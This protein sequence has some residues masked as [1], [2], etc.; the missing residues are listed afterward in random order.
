[1]ITFTTTILKFDEQGEKTGWTYI[2]I[3]E[4]IAVKIKPG[5]KKS[6]RVKGKLDNFSIKG[7]ALLPMG[8]GDFI[9]PL[10]ANMRKA[11]KKRQGAML[12]VAIT[13]DAEEMRPPLEL[14]ECL[15][16]EPAAQACFNK[17]PKSHQ[18]Y[19]TKWINDAKTEQTKTKRIA[20]AVS[21]LAKGM[22]YGEMIRAQKQERDELL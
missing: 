2:L 1:M 13:V 6:F 12:N 11:I 15:Q 7:V 20:Q 4:K 14:I 18:N 3:P 9:M 10:N 21:A 8:G 17:L 19:Y 22:H 16:D 5:N